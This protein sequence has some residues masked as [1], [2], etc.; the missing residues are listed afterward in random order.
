[1]PFSS[2]FLYFCGQH[3]FFVFLEAYPADV[4]PPVLSSSHEKTKKPISQI[5]NDKSKRQQMACNFSIQLGKFRFQLGTRNAEPGAKGSTTPLQAWLGGN[6]HGH[7]E[8]ATLP[9][10]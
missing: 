2:L 3:L 10:L 4:Q 1:M 9:L 7:G 8:G 6:I 5:N